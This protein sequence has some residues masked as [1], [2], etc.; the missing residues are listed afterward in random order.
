MTLI[1]RAIN[2][3]VRVT[4]NTVERP[5]DESVREAGQKTGERW[6]SVEGRNLENLK[7][8]E[9][10]GIKKRKKREEAFRSNTV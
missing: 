9:N 10:V 3:D 1:R 8:A 5:S 2:S 6:V 4:A 7:K